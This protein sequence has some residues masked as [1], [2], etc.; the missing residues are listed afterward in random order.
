M[1]Q[2]DAELVRCGYEATLRGDLETVADLLAADVRLHGGDPSASGACN[3]RG[4]ALEFIGRA[5]GSRAISELVDVIEA[6]PKVGGI[7]RRVSPTSREE[8]SSVANLTTSSDGQVVEMVP[9]PDPAE[10]V[11]AASD[12]RPLS[13]SPPN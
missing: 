6:G 4:T 3:G 13:A 1:M 5:V 9:C 7:P 10:T 8:V 12:G 2:Q 11:T